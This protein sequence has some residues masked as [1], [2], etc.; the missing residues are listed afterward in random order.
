MLPA[1]NCEASKE[2]S[3]LSEQEMDC[4]DS[5]SIPNLISEEENELAE[6]VGVKGFAHLVPHDFKGRE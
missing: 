5:L 2:Q 3:N 6:E 4:R 1:L